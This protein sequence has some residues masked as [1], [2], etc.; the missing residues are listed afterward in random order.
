MWYTSIV[1]LFQLCYAAVHVNLNPKN[2]SAPTSYPMNFTGYSSNSTS[3]F[4]EWQLPQHQSRNGHIISYSIIVRE[5]PTNKTFSLFKTEVSQHLLI[6]LLH[7][8]YEYECRVAASTSIGQGP[9]GPTIIV[10]TLED[11]MF[12]IIFMSLFLLTLWYM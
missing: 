12:E 6:N 2:F 9:F 10:T 3:I 7:P 5:I 1:P 4:L 8:F 11:G